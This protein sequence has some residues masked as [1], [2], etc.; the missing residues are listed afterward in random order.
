MN[1]LITQC[2][3]CQEVL[4][5]NMAFTFLNIENGEVQRNMEQI[6]WRG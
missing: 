5:Y 6:V 2:Q 4:F 3:A 1:F